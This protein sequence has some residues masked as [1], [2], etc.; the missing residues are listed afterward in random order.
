VS[1]AKPI[2]STVAAN[3]QSTI[4]IAIHNRQS[5]MQFNNRQSALQSAITNRQFNQQSS[6]SNPQAAILNQQSD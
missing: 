2:R 1:D 5:F 4:G 6:L 3:P